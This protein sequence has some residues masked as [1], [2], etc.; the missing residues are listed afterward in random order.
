MTFTVGLFWLFKTLGEQTV[1]NRQ[2]KI[3]SFN[4]Q[5]IAE[6]QSLKKR[7]GMI[8]GL[9]GNSKHLFGYEFKVRLS[10]PNIKIDSFEIFIPTNVLSNEERHILNKTKV[11]DK[12]TYHFNFRNHKKGELKIKQ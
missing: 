2:N 8:Q 12:L 1:E 9:D 7:T 4:N 10:S 11:G 6:I 5:A 3:K